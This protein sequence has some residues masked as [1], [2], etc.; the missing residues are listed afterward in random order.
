MTPDRPNIILISTDSLR[1]DA[2]YGSSCETPAHDALAAD[3][4]VYKRAFAQGPFTTFSMPSLFTS[5]YPSGLEYMEFSDSTVG[6]YINDEPTI[7]EVLRELGYETAGFHSN[8]LLSNLFGFDRGFDTFDFQLPFSQFDLFSG[9]MKILTDKLK[10]LF[11]K[12]AYL[13]AEKV[14][15]RAVEWLDSRDNDD[16]FFLWLHY[17]DVHGP[18]QAKS[19]NTYLN[20]YRGERLWRK[21]L[22]HPEQV[23]DSEHEHLRELYDIEVEYTDRC[24]GDLF[25]ALRDRDLFEHSVKVLTADHGE[26]FYEHGA[27]SHP[28]QLYSELTHV[29]LIIDGPNTE[30]GSSDD[31][32]ELVDIAPTLVERVDGTVP[33]SFAGESLLAESVGDEASAISEADLTPAYNGSI[34]TDE[35]R[36]IRDDV[37]DRE[38]LFDHGEDPAEQHDVS[39]EYPDVVAELSGR[40]KTHLEDGERGI[41][42]DRDVA[43]KQITDTDVQDRL[44]DLGY[45]E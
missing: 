2:I 5:R 31:V 33:S 38:L 7:P 12:H 28:N 17:M 4:F 42:P 15:Q 35:W 34:K 9:R 11:R 37:N 36:Y 29:P 13:P 27:Y 6:V 20:K 22:K 24:L 14:N 23:S 10:R 8:P 40:L 18:Y 3:G 25:G 39:E 30:P 32:V 43:R 45:M 21:A 1:A 19:G 16:P 26:Q 44:E 41:G